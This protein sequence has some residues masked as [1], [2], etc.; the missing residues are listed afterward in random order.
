MAIEVMCDVDG[1]DSHAPLPSGGAGGVLFG[2]PVMAVAPKGWTIILLAP[3][4]VDEQRFR[5][6]LED[7]FGVDH[8]AGFGSTR[9]LMAQK[10]ASMPTPPRKVFCCNKHE[11]PKFSPKSSGDDFDD[12]GI[13]VV[14]G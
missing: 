5:K 8:S 13:G 2:A 1:C 12:A 9:E 4:E 10:M 3:T 6:K 7:R 14:M 11:M